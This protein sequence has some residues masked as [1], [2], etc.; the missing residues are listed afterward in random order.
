M[1]FPTQTERTRRERIQAVEV[2]LADG[3]RWGFALPGARLYPIAYHD[4]DASGRTRTRIALTSRVGYPIEV[5][6]LRDKLVSA[7]AVVDLDR[8]DIAFRRLATSLL[9]LA[10]DL[11]P[12]EANALLDPS[13][14]D[15]R[16]I[17]RAL[18]PA[19]F[20]DSSDPSSPGGR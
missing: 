20:A 7:I 10:H 3:R 5:K 14:V 11:E 18:I 1:S 4:S 19:V 17:A 2:Q 13:R 9:L 16:E 8:V 6:Q 12:T 15:L